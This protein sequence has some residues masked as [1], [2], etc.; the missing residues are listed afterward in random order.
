MRQVSR[1]DRSL[2]L[3]TRR[4]STPSVAEGRTTW[5]DGPIDTNV[6]LKDGTKFADISGLRDY[7]LVDRRDNSCDSSPG[8]YSAIR[9]DER[10][11][12]SDE[13]LLAEIQ[14]RLAAND[15]HIQSAILTVIE[16]LSSAVTRTGVAA[17]P[18]T[19]LSL[20]HLSEESY[21]G[22]R[23]RSAVLADADT[24]HGP[25]R[26]GVSMAL[27]SIESLPAWG[28][29]PV[30]LKRQAKSPL[31]F[32]CLFP[33]TDFIARNGGRRGTAGKWSSAKSCNP[34]KNTGKSYS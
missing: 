7:V 34:W 33:G 10:S 1:P 13:P 29:E 4:H 3:R 31:R 5:R 6:Q 11:R 21:H 26:T 16:A 27:P 14:R 24:P 32:A 19:L 28:S 9:S 18:R 8:S 23:Q 12:H 15:Y 20:P 2:R 22:P 30:N 25:S 17:R